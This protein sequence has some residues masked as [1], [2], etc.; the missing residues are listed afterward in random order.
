MTPEASLQMTSHPT[1]L[2][3]Y[4]GLFYRRNKRRS[5]TVGVFHAFERM[6]SASLA[7][8]GTSAQRD[9]EDRCGRPKPRLENRFFSR[10]QYPEPEHRSA[11]TRVCRRF[12]QLAP[13]EIA[14]SKMQRSRVTIARRFDIQRWTKTTLCLVGRRTRELSQRS[15]EKRSN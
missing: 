14:P 6:S 3:A 7:P 12:R 15:S 9:G 4:K 13:G 11:R 1:D 2:Q 5:S 10:R 8:A